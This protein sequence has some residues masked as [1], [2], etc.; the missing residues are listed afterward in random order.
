MVEFPV[1]VK[2]MDQVDRFIQKEAQKTLKARGQQIVEMVRE[3]HH[4]GLNRDGKKMQSGYSTG[5][6]KQ[7]KKKGLQ[8]KFVDLHFSG[9]YHKSL[10]VV[11]QQDGVDIQSTE[12]YAF[13]LRGNFP[14]M[15]GLTPKNAEIVAE[16]IADILAPKI[17]KFLVR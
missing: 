11:P 10:K 13:Y 6:T 14:G 5:Y 2:R 3:Q 7:R 12:P 4:D 1:F 9:K 15:A 16:K 8:T 17:K